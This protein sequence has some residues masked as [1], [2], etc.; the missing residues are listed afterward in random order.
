MTNDAMTDLEL[1][2]R[3]NR[4]ND[5]HWFGMLYDRHSKAVYNKCLL[6]VKEPSE[7]EDVA[8]DIF[9]KAFLGLKQFKKQSQFSTWLYS[10]TYNFCISHLRS[11]KQLAE[12]PD[13]DQMPQPNEVADEDFLQL[14]VMHL[15]K[16]LQEISAEEKM[17]LLMKYQDDM[18]I[19]DIQEALNLGESAVKMRIKRAKA[20]VAELVAQLKQDYHDTNQ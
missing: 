2:E 1:I 13:Y 17:I 5:P 7:A 20:R 8:H 19:K 14:R 18:S 9:V 11:R 15:E 3:I 16:A 6:F 10:I 4:S 12:L